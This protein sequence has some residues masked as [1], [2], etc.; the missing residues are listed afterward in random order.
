VV[1]FVCIVIVFGCVAF[2]CCCVVI[3]WV[4]MKVVVELVW[5]LWLRLCLYWNRIG[6]VFFWFGC[7]SGL[8]YWLM[9][10]RLVVW[11]VVVSLVFCFGFGYIVVRVLVSVR[12]VEVVCFDVMVLVMVCWVRL[13]MWMVVLLVSWLWVI[14]DSW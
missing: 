13:W 12:I 1:R 7:Y 6:C 10:F 9:R 3:S 11:S 4:V 14:S 5:L 8:G 2:N